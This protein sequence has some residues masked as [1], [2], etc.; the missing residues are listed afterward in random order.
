MKE[1]ALVKNTSISSL[2]HN[3]LVTVKKKSNKQK[4][5]ASGA[6]GEGNG[7]PLQNPCL[8]NLMDRRV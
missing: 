6:F 7:N 3:F 5:V 1:N 2:S 4:W 8:E